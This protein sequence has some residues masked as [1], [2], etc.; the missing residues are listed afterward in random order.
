M[1]LVS[2]IKC[3]NLGSL[4]LTQIFLQAFILKAIL[5]FNILHYRKI[6]SVDTGLV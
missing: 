4:F 3:F 1:Q 2:N 5:K 6:F